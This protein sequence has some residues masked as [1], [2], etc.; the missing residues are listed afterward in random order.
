MRHVVVTAGASGIGRAMAEAF[1]AAGDKVAVCDVDENALDAFSAAQGEAL[2]LRADVSDET[3]VA[4]FFNAVE[5]EWGRGP[6]VLL[7]NAGTAGPAGAVDTLDYADWRACIDVNLGGAF[8]CVRRVVPTMR[9]RGDGL[10]LL[11][12]STAGLFGY[13]YRTPYASAKWAIIGFMKSLAL[14]LGPNGIRVNAICPG[15]VNGPRMDRVV[16]KEAAAKGL[17]EE[18]VRRTHVDAVALRRWI[19]VEEL[20]AM[21]LYLASPAA[22]SITGQAVAVDG[23]TIHL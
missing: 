15:A 22:R 6:D 10:I 5:T 4:A 13:S 3:A 9:S 14:E 19:D 2:A 21:A 7:A 20:A 8:L 17:S 12:S 16:A 1:I 23:G 18:K 11:T